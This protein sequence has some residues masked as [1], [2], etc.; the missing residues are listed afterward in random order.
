MK[1]IN[2]NNEGEIKASPEKQK[3]KEF[4]ANTPALQEISFKEVL[5][6]EMKG[7]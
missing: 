3:L 5:Q 2:E 1:I 7:L 6:T 4:I